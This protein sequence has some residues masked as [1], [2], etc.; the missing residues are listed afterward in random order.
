VVDIGGFD[1]QRN[2]GTACHDMGLGVTKSKVRSID[3]TILTNDG[4]CYF[5]IL[6]PRSD[7]ETGSGWHMICASATAVIRLFSRQDSYYN[8]SVFN[9]T[10][11]NRGYV[12]V[13]YTP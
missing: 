4:A 2:T 3:V 7:G 8:N 1:M 9:G 10:V 6:H 5:P 12:T 13:W 11:G